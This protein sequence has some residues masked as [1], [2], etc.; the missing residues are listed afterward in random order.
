M[1]RLAPW[2]GDLSTDKLVGM[3]ICRHC[4]HA[5]EGQDPIVDPDSGESYHVPCLL[6]GVPE[7][8]AVALLNLVA[9]V[10]APA[11]AVWAT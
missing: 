10:G 1:R 11:I 9:T 3:P 4:H 8:A 6:A 2:P 7:E 5:I